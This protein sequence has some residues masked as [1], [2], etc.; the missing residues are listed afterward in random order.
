MCIAPRTYEVKNEAC[1]SNRS[2][3]VSFE[4][5]VSNTDTKLSSLH[6]VCES[7][8]W[9]LLARLVDHWMILIPVRHG[10]DVPLQLHFHVLAIPT[11]YD[12]HKS[13]TRFTFF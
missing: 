9:N 10:S 2:E 8:V 6:F 12:D 3:L 1:D 7:N 13:L 11:P 4:L 5:K